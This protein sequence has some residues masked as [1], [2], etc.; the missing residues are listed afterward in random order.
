[1]PIKTKN[2]TTK[3]DNTPEI[4]VSMLK[5]NTGINFMDSGGT[6]GRKWQQN[7]KLNLKAF[8]SE[9]YVMAEFTEYDGKI[10]VS[11]RKSLYKYLKQYLTYNEK[12]TNLFMR[13]A[14]KPEN[15]DKYWLELMEAFP[16]YLREKGHKVTGLYGEG[17]PISENSYNHDSLLSQVIQFT[18]LEVDNKSL[19]ML[20]IHNG[21]DVRGGYT[22]P[23]IFNTEDSFLCSSNDLEIMCSH[24]SD[25][26][27]LSDNCGYD[28]HF[29]GVWE[30]G[31]IKEDSELFP[32]FVKGLPMPEVKHHLAD[33]T[34]IEFNFEEGKAYC[35]LCY[36]ATKEKHELKV[37]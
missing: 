10:Q 8:E 1:M 30:R 3:K 2:K 20:Q 22:A 36:K 29:N 33:Y 24:N 32:D 14:G 13:W 37:N 15:T 7:A 19:I 6:N 5:E 17:E 4:L 21:A 12:M 27:W 26:V 9:P 11:A 28:A 25:H 34:P 18:Y 23:K 35:P 31:E 16:A